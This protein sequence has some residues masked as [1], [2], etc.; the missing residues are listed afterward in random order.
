MP[1]GHSRESTARSVMLSQTEQD[2]AH[3]VRASQRGDQEAFALLVCRHQR[4]IFN[5]S[6]GILKN[7]DDASESTLEA[8]VAAWQELPDLRDEARFS[9][10]LFRI[11]YQ[12]SLRQLARR[13]R[14]H[15]RHSGGQTEQT[16]V[17]KHPASQGAGTTQG[18][19]WQALV[20][21][22]LEH[23][24]LTSRT[25]LILRH[26]HHQTYEEIA[27]ILSMPTGMVKTRLFRARTLLKERLAGTAPLATRETVSRTPHT[28]NEEVMQ[29]S[30]Q[31]HFHGRGQDS[32]PVNQE[33]DDFSQLQQTWLEL[34]R[35]WMKQQ[36][37]SLDQQEAW[38]QQR[39]GWLD[40]QQ[41][42]IEQ[43]RIWL[44]ERRRWIEQRRD[45]L[46]QQDE[47]LSQQAAWLIQQEA[48]LDQQHTALVQQYSEVVQQHQWVQQRRSW[49]DRKLRW[50]TQQDSA[51]S[52]GEEAGEH[53]SG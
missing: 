44:A 29:P 47:K 24:P 7:E 51:S 38:L 4:R 5:L 30:R 45:W 28:E 36:R 52:Q 21:E 19:D 49:L 35:G 41:S 43:R 53:Q 26:L 25:L 42:W 31:F 10:W 18:Q 2:D 8:F 14:E 16:L 27:D 13:K 23:L 39:R 17:G 12:C 37:S 15:A 20:R 40:Q 1:L 11:T 48:W 3:L 46:T 6:L 34:Q 9:T 22:P 33:Q 50:L 32:T